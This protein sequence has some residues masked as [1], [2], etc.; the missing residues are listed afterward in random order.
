MNTNKA[1][2]TRITSLILILCCVFSLCSCYK[3]PVIEKTDSSSQ[4]SNYVENLTG[5]DLSPY[6][7]QAEMEVS[8]GNE[9][10]SY[11]KI[12]LSYNTSKAVTKILKEKTRMDDN[13][14]VKIPYFSNH[15]FAVEL[16][17]DDMLLTGHYIKVKEENTFHTRDIDIYT[18]KNGNLYYVFI[19]G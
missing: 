5:V 4:I 16:K 17:G 19:F 18:T 10:F 14:E 12:T 9:E 13:P 3:E 15:P 2:K 8:K 11:I 1:A 7:A 6:I